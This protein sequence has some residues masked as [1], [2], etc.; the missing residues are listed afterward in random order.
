MEIYLIIPNKHVDIAEQ[1]NN[2]LL[3]DTVKYASKYTDQTLAPTPLYCNNLTLLSMAELIIPIF[4]DAGKDFMWELGYCIGK[5]PHKIRFGIN[6]NANTQ[7]LM[8]YRSIPRWITFTQISEA[9][10]EGW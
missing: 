4:I 7:D 5:F 9:V 10:K 1:I 3:P 2:L 6:L 8:S